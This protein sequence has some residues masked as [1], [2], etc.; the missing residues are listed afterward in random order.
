MTS[1]QSSNQTTETHRP[2]ADIEHDLH[3]ASENMSL[4]YAIELIRALYA[5]EAR[6]VDELI[7]ERDD[8]SNRAEH[9]GFR[10]GMTRAINVVRM[11]MEDQHG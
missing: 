2:L 11:Q 7:K 5:R 3:F 9:T 6:L 10:A 8:P 1:K 4:H